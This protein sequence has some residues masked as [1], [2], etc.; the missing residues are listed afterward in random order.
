MSLRYKEITLTP[1]DICLEVFIGKKKD[2]VKKLK[3]DNG[4]KKSYWKEMIGDSSCVVG[5]ENHIFMFLL[6][7]DI[8]TI[9]HESV[10]AT[11]FLDEIVGFNFNIESQEMQAYYVDYIVGEILKMK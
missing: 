6:E 3:K 1:T 8:K 5:L 2:I 10:H 4:E 7:D 11:W 9:V